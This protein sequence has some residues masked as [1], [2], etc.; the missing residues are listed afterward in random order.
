M[1]ADERG[2]EQEEEG[3]ETELTHFKSFSDLRLSA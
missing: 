3:K 2:S 1:N